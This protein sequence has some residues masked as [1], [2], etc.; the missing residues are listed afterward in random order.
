MTQV[1]IGP[2]VDRVAF[3]K[4][5]AI[6]PGALAARRKRLEGRPCRPIFAPQGSQGITIG[7]IAFSM[8]NGGIERGERHASVGQMQLDPISRRRCQLDLHALFEAV[9][10]VQGTPWFCLPCQYSGY[11]CH[12]HHEY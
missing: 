6:A 1:H 2:V 8:G 9:Q 10:R 7:R 12:P 4:L 11:A 3:A 5:R